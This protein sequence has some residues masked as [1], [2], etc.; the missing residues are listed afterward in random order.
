L[1]ETGFGYAAPIVR[2]VG[3]IRCALFVGANS[4][5]L[6]EISTGKKL[7][8]WPIPYSVEVVCVPDPVISDGKVFFSMTEHSYLLDLTGNPP[9][10]LWINDA[11]ASMVASPI[12][13]QG[14]L[15]GTQF[16]ED[17]TTP[18][19]F[20]FADFYKYPTPFR[21]VEFATGKVMWQVDDMKYVSI[22]FADGK[23]VMLEP[24]GTLHIGEGTPEGYRE[25]SAADVLAGEN[26][27]RRFHAPPVLCGGRIYCRN[28]E[29]DLVCIDVSK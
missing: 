16:H 5:S 6:I 20:S 27:P 2:D 28:Y 29:G 24:N 18:K 13:F 8:S 9:K 12:F 17:T 11:L 3:G 15:Y 7:W 22:L 23:L 19:I 1:P 4:A 26:R 14:Y 25:F 10:P 21:C